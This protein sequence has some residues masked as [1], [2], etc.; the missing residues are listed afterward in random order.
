[1]G[2]RD[3]EGNVVIVRLGNGTIEAPRNQKF[4]VGAR[5]VNA[6]AIAR[7]F[8]KE[9]LRYPLLINSKKP[10]PEPLAGG[11]II[12]EMGKPGHRPDIDGKARRRSARLSV[13][14]QVLRR[15][16]VGRQDECGAQQGCALSFVSD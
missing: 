16:L 8:C 5:T 3:D 14:N 2:L 6:Q 9:F 7:Q 1:P 4:L 15:L 11:V 13:A 12:K 10:L